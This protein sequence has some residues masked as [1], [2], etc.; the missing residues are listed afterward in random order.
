[1]NMTEGEPECHGSMF[2]LFAAAETEI[3]GMH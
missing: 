1:L 2:R 3:V